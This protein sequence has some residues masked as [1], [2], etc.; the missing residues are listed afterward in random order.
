MKTITYPNSATADA[1]S[2]RVTPPKIEPNCLSPFFNDFVPSSPIAFIAGNLPHWRQD[3]TTYFVTFRTADS[4]PQA[5]LEQWL[6]ERLAWIAAN[7]EPHSPA[8]RLDYNERFPQRFHDWLDQGHGECLLR[9]PEFRHV[10][11]NALRYF[12]NDRYRL[13]EFVVMPNHVH[14]ILAPLGEHRLSSIIGSWKSFTAKVINNRLNR[15]GPFW[16]QESFDHIV[17]NAES[18]QR[19]RN[20]IQDN[21]K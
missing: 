1:A 10:V 6:A 3:G 4:M 8:Q 14:A 2:R 13:D 18:L 17:R 16:Q 20:Y 21:P 12:D 5:K 19:F 11:E 7:P 9:Q 15:S